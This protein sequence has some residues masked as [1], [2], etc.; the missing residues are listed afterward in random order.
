VSVY[1]ILDQLREKDLVIASQTSPKRF[2]ARSP[3][4]GIASLID[5]VERSADYARRELS[6]VYCDRQGIASSS[7]E[8][9][10]N[11]H[12]FENIRK[13]LVELIQGAKKEIRIMGHFRIL[14]EEVQKILETR[15]ENVDTEIITSSW[16]GTASGPIRLY[17]MRPPRTSRRARACQGHDRGRGLHHRW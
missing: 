8:L 9:I 15:A 13:Q 3:E 6:V 4:Q 12:G 7:D 17:I 16:T 14:Q 1:P 11:V 2:A 5:R 10:W